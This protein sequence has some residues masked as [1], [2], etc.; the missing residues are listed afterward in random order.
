MDQNESLS[1]S[2]QQNKTLSLNSEHGK[3]LSLSFEQEQFI[4]NN[5]KLVKDLNLLTKKVFE[6]E[7]IDG[8]S[9]EGKLIR[10]FL[11]RNKREYKTT[12]H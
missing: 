7:D 5:Y 6:N 11:V 9:I 2:V 10:A 3:P 12:K 1:L 4:L 8:R